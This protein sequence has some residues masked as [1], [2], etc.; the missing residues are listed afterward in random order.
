M[1]ASLDPHVYCSTADGQC[2]CQCVCVWFVT[3]LR[4]AGSHDMDTNLK[5]FPQSE[6]ILLIVTSSRICCCVK[7]RVKIG[8]E[9]TLKLIEDS[10]FL[11][12]NIKSVNQRD[13]R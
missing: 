2:R 13:L 11:L 12:H 10:C 9:V 7:M 8:V 6:D 4:M 1:E 5:R 3:L